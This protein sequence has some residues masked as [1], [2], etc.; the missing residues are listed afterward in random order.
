MITPAGDIK[1]MTVP[2]LFQELRSEKKTGTAVFSRDAA[3]KKVFFQ[4]GDI[5]FASSNVDEDRLG[6]FLLRAKRITQAQYDV[7]SEIVG[8]TGKKLGAVLVELG[9]ISPQ[10][11]VSGVK[12][13][14][15]Q[16]ILGL[17]GWR[18]G[19]YSFDEGPLPIADIIPLHMSTGNV[20]IEGV[21]GLEWGVVRKSLPPLKTTLRPA[22]DPS[23]LFQ[24]A[25]LEL[26]H[27]SVLGLID[28]NR[29][30]E[31]LCSLSGMGD[32]N[33]LKTI[34]VLLAL[35]MI[36]KGEIRTEEEKRFVRE[37]V[38]ETVTAGRQSSKDRAPQEQRPAAS[39]ETAAAAI[40]RQAIQDAFDAIKS[41]DHYQVLGVAAK[42]TSQEIK[43]AYFKLAKVYHPDRHFEPEM[44]DMKGKL[45]LLFT[46][47]HD[48]YQT[49][50]DP[51]RRQ[52]YNLA[53]ARKPSSAQYEERRPEDYVENAAEKAR[54][55]A[56]YYDAG[57]NDFKG[58]NF[59][60]AAE[61][62]AWATRLNPEKAP[63]FYYYGISLSRI[64]RRKHEAEENLRRAIAI[65]RRKPEYYLELGSLYLKG[66]LKTKAIAVYN[67]ALR[68]NPNSDK[69]REALD[70]A[71]AEQPEE[72]EGA[73]AGLFSKRFKDKK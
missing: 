56:A 65:D 18:T 23:L 48:A 13:Q 67:E 53:P 39:T 14:V 21:R 11:L 68:E 38:R 59:L 49:L 20:I 71:G 40:T 55:A 8:K 15:K 50:S 64:P 46:R 33:T 32:F 9:F 4:G 52:E 35:K 36:E 60:G 37:V 34:F 54:Q 72:K 69:I 17:F 25:D 47:I 19:N 10:D 27:R 41:Q 1:D 28:G 2:W 62:L 22:S 70:A 63:Y 12:H 66:G 73:S 3:V 43:K 26:D 24:S 16:I 6:D 29:N 57:M 42:A 58:G 5:I 61:S 51:A 7:S 44:N 45:E 31:E 30:L